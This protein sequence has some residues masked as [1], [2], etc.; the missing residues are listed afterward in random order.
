MKKV[1]ENIEG[2][3]DNFKECNIYIIR[4]LEEKKYLK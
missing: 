2:Q 1:Q 3:C 4:T